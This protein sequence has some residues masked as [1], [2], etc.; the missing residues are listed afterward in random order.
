MFLSDLCQIRSKRKMRHSHYYEDRL[1][2]EPPPCLPCYSEL[3]AWPLCCVKGRIPG[4]VQPPALTP[5][6]SAGVWAAALGKA[7]PAFPKGLGEPFCSPDGSNLRPPLSAGNGLS[8]FPETNKTCFS[9]LLGL[10]YLSLFSQGRR[11]TPEAS[12]GR[13]SLQGP[14][15][16]GHVL[17]LLVV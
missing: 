14:T 12:E 15:E 13:K 2:D 17:Q 4:R 8:F 7:V 10:K 1:L 5:V 9:I 3:V 6:V 16:V 11:R